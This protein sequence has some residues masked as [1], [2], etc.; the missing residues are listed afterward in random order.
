MLP[1][2]YL[3]SLIPFLIPIIGIPL[4]FFTGNHFHEEDREERID[5]DKRQLIV[6]DPVIFRLN[7]DNLRGK[8]LARLRGLSMRTTSTGEATF[9]TDDFNVKGN[10][11]QIQVKRCKFACDT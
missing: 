1:L 4:G 6:P 8:D 7:T 2:I 11:T 5:N 3:L 10:V 9:S